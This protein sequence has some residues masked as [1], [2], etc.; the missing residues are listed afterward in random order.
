[1]GI[2]I[3]VWVNY[4]PNP[5]YASCISVQGKFIYATDMKNEKYLLM[6]YETSEQAQIEVNR[7]HKKCNLHTAYKFPSIKQHKNYERLSKKM[8][9]E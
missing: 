2:K 3:G 6:E 9:S 1:M 7:F 8:R 5:I 4:K